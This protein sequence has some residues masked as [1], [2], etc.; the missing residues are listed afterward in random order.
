MTHNQINYFVARENKRSHLASE[1]LTAEQNAIGWRNAEI[2]QQNANTNAMNAQTNLLAV[3]E[4][5]RHNAASEAIAYQQDAT[6]QRGQTIRGATDTLHSAAR[7]GVLAGGA[8][9]AAGAGASMAAAKRGFMSSSIMTKSS[10]GTQALLPT[11][12]LVPIPRSE[13]KR[14]LTNARNSV[15]H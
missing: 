15:L 4:T 11:L 1:Q 6:T 10:A 13:L 2:A 7:F 3:Q 5:Q 8:A 9:V 12:A 14:D